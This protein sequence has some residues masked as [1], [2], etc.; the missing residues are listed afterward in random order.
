M[1]GMAYS[2]PALSRWTYLSNGYNFLESDDILGKAYL[3]VFT[4]KGVSD[5]D[6]REHKGNSFPTK[7]Y[8]A[9]NYKSWLKQMTE[10]PI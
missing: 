4:A 3:N 6:E 10:N 8:R 2:W 1:K 5:D 9:T 7:N